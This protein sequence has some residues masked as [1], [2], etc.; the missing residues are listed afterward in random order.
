[1]TAAPCRMYKNKTF[2]LSFDTSTVYKS[3]DIIFH[4]LD[5]LDGFKQ[6]TYF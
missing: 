5:F 4:C 3:V 2:H 6:D 1:M